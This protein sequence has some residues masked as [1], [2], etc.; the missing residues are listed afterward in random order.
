M[1]NPDVKVYSCQSALIGGLS[2]I[3]LG[4]GNECMLPMVDSSQ[5]HVRQM[6]DHSPFTI[7]L[8]LGAVRGKS[9]WKLNPFWLSLLPDPDPIPELLT[10]FFRQN[11]G[12]TDMA[13]VWEAAKAYLRGQFIRE[14]SHIKTKTKEW[15]N[16]VMA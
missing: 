11:I 16:L 15:K 3:D 12:S 7:D 9:L 8:Q 10:S 13:M 1:H 14:I 6:S 4:L 5:Y 2:R